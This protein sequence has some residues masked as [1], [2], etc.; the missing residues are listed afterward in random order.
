M[1][2]TVESPTTATT[3]SAPAFGTVLIANRGEIAERLIRSARAMGLRTVAVYSEADAGSVHTRSADV[4][5][6]LGATSPAESYLNVDKI[7]AAMHETGADAVHPG[8]GF[9]SENTAFAQA[10]LDNGFVFVGPTVEQLRLFAD[11]HTARAAAA[12][13]GVALL[14]GSGLLAD[15]DHAASAAATIGYPVILKATSGGGGI[16]L[17]PCVDEAELRAAFDRVRRLAESNFGDAG[18]F[19]ERYVTHARHVEVQIFGDGAGTV[20]SVGD[21]DC[22][23]QR[24]NQKVLEEAPAPNLPDAVRARMHASARALTASVSYRGAGTVEFVYDTDRAE[25]SFLEVNTRL[26]VEH[27]VTEAVTGIDLVAWMFRLARGENVLAGLGPE[28]PRINGHAVQARVYAEDPGRDFQPSSGLLTRVEFPSGP[29]VDTWV[30]TGQRVGTA[31][32]PMLAKVITHADDRASAFDRLADALADTRIDGLHTNLGLL[33]ALCVDERVRTVTHHTGTCATVVDR[34]ARIDV[35]RAGTL[36]TVQDW[37]GRTGYWQVG[38]PPSG[39]MDDL[40]FRLGNSALGNPEG[41]TG[42]ECTL[43]GPRLRFAHPATICVTGAAATVTVDDNPVSQWEPVTVGAGAVLDIGMALGPGMRTYLLIRGGLAVPTYLGSA[44]TFTAGEFGGHGGRALRIGDTLNP[45]AIAA[46]A[47]APQPVSESVRPIFDTDWRIEVSEGPHAAPEFL[48]RAGLERFY[49]AEWRVHPQSARTGVRL[50]GPKQLW[51]RA[52]GG[53]AGL[54]PSNVHD[55]AYSVGAVNVSGDTPVLLGPDGPSLGGFVCPV[56]VVAGARWKLGQLRPGDT[57]RFVPVTEHT[58]ASMRPRRGPTLITT[59][60]DGDDG[61]LARIDAGADTPSVTYRRSAHDNLLVEYGPMTLDLG[62]RLRVHAL[63]RA[64]EHH[65]PQGIIDLTPGVRS[66]HLHTDPDRLPL[67]RLLDLLIELEEQLPPTAQLRVPSR[68]VRLPMS[69]DDPSIHEAIERYCAGVRDDAPWNPDNIEFIRRI[70]GLDSVDDV[71]EIVFDA[72]YLVLGLGDVYLGA[73]AATPLDPRH[74]L[75]TTKYSPAR[76]W[77]PEAGVGIGGAYLCVY[78]MES[79]GG[80]QLIGRTVPIWSG[81]RQ[82]GP[83]DPGTPW[84][85]RFFDRISFYPVAPDE[86]LELRAD[87]LAGRHEIAIDDGEFVL[88]AHERMLAENAESIAAFRHKQQVAFRDER[89]AWQAAGE[90]DERPE[91]EPVRAPAERALPPGSDLVQAPLSA[92]V[93][94]VDVRPGDTVAAGQPLVRLEAMKLE[95]TVRAPAAGVV[96]DLF[97]APGQHLD[98]GHAIAVIAHRKAA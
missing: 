42:L 41:T 2:D 31:Y 87:L 54:H 89:A 55:T 4:A 24:R 56:T 32:D 11:K 77:T 68:T 28:G 69:F 7:I 85:L 39:P 34:T 36:T 20:I 86:L 46:D 53:E 22:T 15:A 6:A 52:D 83:F 72:E 40:S 58:A 21:R 95:V 64:L 82:Y 19:V 50:A 84:L 73:P 29:R 93:W 3:S 37:P 71:R 17:R 30:E 70:N 61:V 88:A 14:P 60:T 79:P 97:I 63:M 81:L 45:A 44:A 94:A 75:V 98:A 13:A 16:G 78:G 12:T 96:T 48:T 47:P 76:T 67:R 5:V 23:V 33:R 57:V 9:L 1:F 43:E 18:V 51:A 38:V 62:L 92:T 8:Y 80:Y 91:P 49:G 26:Q 35:L 10:V 27:P 74:R 66:L 59:G 25:V 90:F 65:A